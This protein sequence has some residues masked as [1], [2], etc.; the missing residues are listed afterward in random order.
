MT[1]DFFRHARRRWYLYLVLL[2]IWTLAYIRV[3]FDAT[4]RLP[5]LFNVSGSLPY[6]MAIVN[7]RA[8]G[9]HRGDFVI[10]AFEGP[11]QAVFPGL[12][13]QPFFKIVRGVAGDKVT[14][15]GRRVYVNG[16]EVGLAKTHTSVKHIP[17]DPIADIVI[18]PSYF[19][20]QGTGV[21]SF[22]S[23]YRINGLVPARA[24]LGVVI[25]LF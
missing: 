7:Y 22:D 25:P 14:V 13:H 17:L 10:Y 3:F 16:E 8:Q 9:I 2:G 19:Y 20:V 24:I 5:I 6:T 11:A 18:P 23:R 12:H 1:R 4:P 15:L 21:D